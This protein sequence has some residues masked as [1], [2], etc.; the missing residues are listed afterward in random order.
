MAIRDIVTRG[1]GNGTYDPGV[2]DVPVRGFT[3]GVGDPVVY[4]A[5]KVIGYAPGP[6]LAGGFSQGVDER[7]IGFGPG[8]AA[9]T[10]C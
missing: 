10:G 8:A 1:Y 7:S 2:A 5:G 3:I 4:C 6:P 9:A